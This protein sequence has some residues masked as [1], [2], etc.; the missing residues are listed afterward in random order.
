MLAKSATFLVERAIATTLKAVRAESLRTPLG[1][2]QVSAHE[3]VYMFNGKALP[4]QRLALTQVLLN[5]AIDP[6]DVLKR[7]DSVAY[8]SARS[9]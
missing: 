5:H 7:G 4:H 1:E 8:L 6:I 3:I 9:L 2:S